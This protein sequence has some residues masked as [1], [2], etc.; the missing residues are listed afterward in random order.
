MNIAKIAAA[1]LCLT[2]SLVASEIAFSNIQEIESLDQIPF[3][4]LTQND[5]VAFDLDDTTFTPKRLIMR[6]PNFDEKK[7][8]TEEIRK[9]AGNERVT[10]M[11][12]H[13]DYQLVE[14]S[15]L[16]HL[17]IL[18]NLGVTTVGFTGRRPGKATSDQQTSNE[19]N[20]LD[21]LHKLNVSFYSPYFQNME[22]KGMNSSNPEYAD[23]IMDKRVRP[24]DE[25]GNVMVKEDVIFCNNIYKAIVLGKIFET[26]EFFPET[27]VF[28]DDKLKNITEVSIAIDK[29]NEKYKT[30]I[31][32]EGY[33]YTHAEKRMNNTINPDIASL[34]KEY[35]LKDNPVFLTDEEALALL[36]QNQ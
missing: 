17:S 31:L 23:S 21:I 7:S 1:S 10:F 36:E 25:P 24:F 18:N 4:K 13:N 16:S 19:D 28:I 22:F 29:I 3:F 20:T 11:Y 12:D 27:F 15:M 35:L 30:N 9:V 14:E 33:F 34:Q 2:S 8:F 5:C 6:D 32:Y 26:V